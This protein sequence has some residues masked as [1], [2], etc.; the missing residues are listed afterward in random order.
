MRKLLNIALLSAIIFLG[1]T[2]DV[3]CAVLKSQF[4]S[5]Q[6][7]NE[8]VTQLK[9][10][11]N[12]EIEINIK[13]LPYQSI[14]IPDG[15]VEIKS[16]INNLNSTSIVKVNIYVD[17]VKV[18]SFGVR[19]EIK[20]K[21][22]VWVAKN[23]IKRGE[24]LTGIT[25]EKKNVTSIYNNLPGKDFEPISYRA[26]MNIKPG[27]IIELTNI[28]EIPTIVK[29]SP[30]SLIFKTPTVSVTIPAVAVTSGKTG[31]FI[32]VKSQRFRKN[33]V[34]KIIGENLVLVNI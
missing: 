24:V 3:Q 34:G 14:Q 28:E 13:S 9:Q 20:I 17:Q 21:D 16:E 31:D 6:V 32:K 23:W 7:K 29:N 30:V 4:I 10:D 8:I 18:K 33:Y 2:P 22:N 15:K 1:F 5:D 11:Y 27:K 26:R 19:A 25:M 12:G